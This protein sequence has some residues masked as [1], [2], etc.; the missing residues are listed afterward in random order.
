MGVLNWA[1]ND[2]LESKRQKQW[3]QLVSRPQERLAGRAGAGLNLDMQGEESQ[4]QMEAGKR[5]G[6]CN[7]PRNLEFIG[8]SEGQNSGMVR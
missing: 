4:R 3:E 2:E 5:G 6:L 7:D 8:G 1:L